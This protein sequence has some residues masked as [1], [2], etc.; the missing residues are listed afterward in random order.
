MS[1]KKL[2]SKKWRQS[3]C[4]IRG[5]TQRSQFNETSEG[6]FVTSGYVYSSPEEAEKT[7]TGDIKRY[8]Y[9]RFSNPTLSMFEKRLALLEGAENC[10][11][12][13]S[14]MAAMFASLLSQLQ[15]GDRVVASRAL[16]GSCLQILREILP[17]YGI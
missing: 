8:Q 14:G 1:G 13:A 6:M 15:S 16:F 2:N 5:G 10:I 11:S 17:K 3:T 12:T 4:L 7:F 9:S